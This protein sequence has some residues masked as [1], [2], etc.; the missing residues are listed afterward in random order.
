MV[1]SNS[2][3]NGPVPT[4]INNSPD[5]S[6]IQIADTATKR[7]NPM[8]IHNEDAHFEFDNEALDCDAPTKPVDAPVL[9]SASSEPTEMPNHDASQGNHSLAE[10]AASA[11]SD[12]MAKTDQ[13]RLEWLSRELCEVVEKQREYKVEIEDLEKRLGTASNGGTYCQPKDFC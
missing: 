13:E 10:S 6:S 12:Q 3:I 11:S 9:P 2:V 1:S 8:S 5:A 4:T 7:N